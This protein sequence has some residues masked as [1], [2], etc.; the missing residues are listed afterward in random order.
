MPARI[1]SV[2]DMVGSIGRDVVEA[3]R[4]AEE[5]M[6]HSRGAVADVSNVHYRVSKLE[7]RLDAVEQI[8]RTVELLHD[9][10]LARQRREAEADLR[11]AESDRTRTRRYALAG[12]LA[13]LVVTAAT[14]IGAALVQGPMTEAAR[15]QSAEVAS[16]HI[17]AQLDRQKALL[18]EASARQQREWLTRVEGLRAEWAREAAAAARAASVREPDQ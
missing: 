17:D 14:T 8:A 15:A 3:R 18:D 10:E 9:A 5:A 11:E 4:A 1:L 12:T 7:Q 16:Q 2:D 13:T 6:Q